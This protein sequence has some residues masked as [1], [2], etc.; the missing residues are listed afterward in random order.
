M[1]LMKMFLVF[2]IAFACSVAQAQQTPDPLKQITRRFPNSIKIK[3]QGRQIEF[4]PDNTCDGFAAS[5][6]ISSTQLKNF[7][8]IYLFY[9][10]GY[11]DLDE[12]RTKPANRVVAERLLRSPEFTSCKEQNLRDK[13]RC[14]LLLLNRKGVRLY[15]V[16]YD[17]GA[18]NVEDLDVAEDT[19]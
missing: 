18:R 15:G 5:K 12:W 3:K 2:V 19:K 8:Y 4:C 10:S 9:F 6:K 14:S 17:E 1:V 16:R 11:Y 7:A 13:A